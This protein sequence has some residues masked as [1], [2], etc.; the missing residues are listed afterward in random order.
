MQKHRERDIG[1]Y[2][3][4]SEDENDGTNNAMGFAA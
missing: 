1:L 3:Y 4:G 2:L